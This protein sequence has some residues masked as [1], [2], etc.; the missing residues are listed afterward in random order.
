MLQFQVIDDFG[1]PNLPVSNT[2]STLNLDSA[3]R[4][5]EMK[6]TSDKSKNAIPMSVTGLSFDAE[7]LVF[8][9]EVGH[10]ANTSLIEPVEYTI[11]TAFRANIPGATAQVYSS[12][13]EATSPY[14]GS[15][16]A[17]TSTGAIAVNVGI[18]G[19]TAGVTTSVIAPAWEVFA[20]SVSETELQL[21]RGS[22]MGRL[23]APLEN[24]RMALN[25][26][27]LG[28]GY[29]SPHNIGIVGKMGV[30]AAYEGILPDSVIVDLMAKIRAI[31][32]SRGVNLP[33]A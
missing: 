3:L 10:Q 14:S 5:Y 22:N 7:G 18:S 30:W 17:V 16:M 11:L 8:D 6:N 33:T 29:L 20:I 12:L 28:G 21:T 26:I 23:T 32:A 25:S 13:A 19:P 1:N 31:M 27:L 4:I 24:R 15:R 2:G 9:G